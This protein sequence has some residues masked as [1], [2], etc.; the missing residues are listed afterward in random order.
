MLSGLSGHY[1]PNGTTFDTENRCPPGSYNPTTKG[2][3]SSDCLE[4]PPGKYCAGYANSAYTGNCSA[5]WYCTGGADGPNT[6]THGGQCSPGYYCPEGQSQQ[7][8]MLKYIE[9]HFL[10]I[11]LKLQVLV[12]RY[13]KIV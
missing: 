10:V 6:T 11:V 9:L 7:I 3:Q 5:G 1:C 4:C 12:Y 2:T 13:I 8:Y